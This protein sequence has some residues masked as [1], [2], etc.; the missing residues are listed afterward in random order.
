MAA[1]ERP[2]AGPNCGGMHDL[3][4]DDVLQDQRQQWQQFFAALESFITLDTPWTL[5]LTDPLANTFVA[6]CTEDL[7]DDPRLTMQVIP[8]HGLRFLLMQVTSQEALVH[9]LVARLILPDRGELHDAQL[10]RHGGQQQADI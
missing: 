5:V 6:P 7:A 2:L 3:M 4:P 1:C 8:W 10:T 9:Q